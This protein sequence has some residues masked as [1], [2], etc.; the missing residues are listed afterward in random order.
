[1][2]YQNYLQ[3]NIFDKYAPNSIDDFKSILEKNELLL[4]G[5]KF[6]H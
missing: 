1:L 5:I 4:H 2:K 3:A 6:W